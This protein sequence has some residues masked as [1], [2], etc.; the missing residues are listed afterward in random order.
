MIEY[1]GFYFK[2]I[3]KTIVVDSGQIILIPRKDIDKWRSG[4]FG[5]NNDYTVMGEGLIKNHYHQLRN[6]LGISIDDGEYEVHE[7]IDS[8]NILILLDEL[9][10]PYQYDIEENDNDLN[11]YESKDFDMYNGNF[12]IIDPC[13]IKENRMELDNEIKALGYEKEGEKYSNVRLIYENFP[14]RNINK[15]IVIYK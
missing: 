4:E 12:I 2:K 14:N 10:N 13:Y 3:L 6:I 8:G 9:N 7:D 11:D 5:D 15:A 1:E